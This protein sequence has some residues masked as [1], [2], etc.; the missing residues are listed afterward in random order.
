MKKT[1][2]GNQIGGAGKDGS[3]QSTVAKSRM[4]KKPAK[5]N[6][7]HKVQKP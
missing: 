7:K 4:P 2:H 5:E 1:K 6:G 3:H